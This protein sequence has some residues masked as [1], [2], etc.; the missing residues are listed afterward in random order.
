MGEVHRA[1]RIDINTGIESGI[2]LLPPP[3]LSET[4]K[5]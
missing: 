4:P 1:F 2:E 3:A 5:P